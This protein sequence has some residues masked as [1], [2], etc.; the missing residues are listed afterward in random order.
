[1]SK[2]VRKDNAVLTHENVSM[3]SPHTIV[4]AKLV[5]SSTW[6]LIDMERA[7]QVMKIVHARNHSVHIRSKTLSFEAKLVMKSNHGHW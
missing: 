5:F 6:K 3:S 7:A 4:S 2:N 1:M